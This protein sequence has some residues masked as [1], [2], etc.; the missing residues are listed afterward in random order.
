MEF[1]YIERTDELFEIALLDY[2]PG[3]ETLQDLMMM[4]LRRQAAEKD[5]NDPNSPEGSKVKR[6]AKRRK[7]GSDDDTSRPRKS[8]KTP[9]KTKRKRKK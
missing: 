4:E 7:T 1:I 6:T 8:K 3:S 5:A 9:G 2:E